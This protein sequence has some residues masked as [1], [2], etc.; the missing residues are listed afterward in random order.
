MKRFKNILL[1]AKGSI[2]DDPA[3]KRAVALAQANKATLTIADVFDTRYFSRMKIGTS[4]RLD[5]VINSV[6]V[7]SREKLS[8]LGR[9]LPGEIDVRTRIFSGKPFMEIIRAVLTEGYDLVMKTIEPKP[10]LSSM[11]F[12]ATDL[13]LLRKCP[14]PVWLVKPDDPPATK[15]VLAA[16]ELESFGDDEEMDALN[17]KIIEV[18]TS[19][20]EQEQGDVHFVNAWVLVGDTMLDRAISGLYKDDIEE[21]MKNQKQDI[22]TRQRQFVD[23]LTTHIKENGLEALNCQHHFIEGE[24]EDVIVEAARA[25]KA[26]LVI[27]GTVGRTDLAGFFIGNTSEQVLSQLNCSVLAIK[28]ADFVSPVTVE[29]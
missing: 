18:A 12:G 28:P 7:D 29:T 25:T 24:A 1:I 21:W 3:F 27:M 20:G 15:T 11:L 22:E 13:H 14:C 8:E 5:K 4:L 16:V 23:S 9:T 2:E 26:D 19:L 17:R 6:M 10:T